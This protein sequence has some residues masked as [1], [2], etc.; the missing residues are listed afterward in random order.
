MS[1]IELKTLALELSDEDR[2]ELAASLFN[3]LDLPDPHDADLDSITEARSRSEELDS[4]T[5]S[6]IPENE[7]WAMVQ[8]DRAK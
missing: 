7:F 6:A 5:V 8:A 3:S 4:G 2:G 1:L